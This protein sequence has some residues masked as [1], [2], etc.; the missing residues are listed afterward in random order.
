MNSPQW[1]L[2]TFQLVVALIGAVAASLGAL[3]YFRRVRMERPA[4]GRFNGRD[5]VILFT[6]LAILPAF[7]LLVPRWALESLLVITYMAAL[8]IGFQPLLRPVALW[9]G[10][11]LLVGADLWFGQHALGTVFGWQVFW[12]ENSLIVMLAA[13]SVANLYVQGGMQLRHVAWFAAGLAIYDSIFTIGFPIT[14]LLV[15]DFVGY[16]L[17]PAMGMRIS[18]NEA[19]VGLGDLLVYAAFT[20]AAYKAY[21]K[22]A[23]RIALVLILVFGAAMPT[24][25]GLLIN[26]IDARLDVIIPA[27]T[28]FGPAALL[29]YL[30][31]RHRYGPERTMK[32]YLA[33]TDAVRREPPAPPAMP[34][35]STPEAVS[36]PVSA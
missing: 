1:V 12:T 20:I 27:Q 13:I 18:F 34:E 21:G 6:L 19:I 9:L 14:N 28:W 26:Y 24:L 7:Y 29:G 16:P 8:S 35:E 32:E 3:V 30:W 10:I 11:G 23:L 15:R 5:V 31:M 22:R 2:S 36:K 25:S 17:F 33:S 4:V